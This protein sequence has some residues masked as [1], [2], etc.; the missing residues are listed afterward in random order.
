MLLGYRLP[1]AVLPGRRSPG[2][3]RE[4]GHPFVGDGHTGNGPFLLHGR[5]HLG[6]RDGCEAGGVIGQAVRD[7]QLAAV[8][9]GAAGIDDVG[10]VTFTLVLDSA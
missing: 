4:D 1:R 2:Y 7:D 5:Q 9:Q 10:H 3:G 8:D 6:E